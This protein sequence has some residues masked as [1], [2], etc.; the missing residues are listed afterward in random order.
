[1]KWLLALFLVV[2]AVP[3]AAE[4]TPPQPRPGRPLTDRERALLLPLFA[5]GLDYDAVRVIDGRFPFQPQNR[6][7]SPEGN[8]Y[9][10]GHLYRADFA[11]PGVDVWTRAIFI[12]EVTHVWQHQSG[13]NLLAGGTAEFFKRRG[14]YETA[15]AYALVADRDLIDYGM[16]QQASIV[17]DWHLIASGRPPQRLEGSLPRAERDRLYRVVLGR[18]LADPAYA[19][20]TTGGAVARRHDWLA[21]QPKPAASACAETP[22]EHAARHNCAWR[23]QVKPATGR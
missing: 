6:Y 4:S 7:M 18:F 15:Y 22:A 13:M 2:A 21:S 16:E 5:S 11:A 3:A 23:Y 17:E 14:A 19:R 12:H 9:A 8:I 10:P 20:A 1:M